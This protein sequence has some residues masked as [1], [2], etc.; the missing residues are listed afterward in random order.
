MTTTLD[1]TSDELL[2]T[3]RSGER[4]AAEVL[5]IPYDDYSQVGM[6]PIAYTKGVD[7]KPARRLV[8]E[9]VTHWNGW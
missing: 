9:H 3:T 6:F 4:A 2:S 8:P 5:T 1:L 7:F